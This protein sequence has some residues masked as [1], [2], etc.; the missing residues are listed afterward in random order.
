MGKLIH[1][2]HI[3]LEAMCVFFRKHGWI[4][5]QW[6]SM[7][8]KVAHH[9]LIQPVDHTGIPMPSMSIYLGEIDDGH[10]LLKVT[11]KA[12]AMFGCDL[13]DPSSLDRL[14]E[15]LDTLYD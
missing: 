9:A 12:R 11:N 14:G 8:G 6:Y 2:E 5:K 4:I 15:F 1:D 3:E 13:S 10:T 7:V